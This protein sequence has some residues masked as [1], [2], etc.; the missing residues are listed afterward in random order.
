M[1]KNTNLEKLLSNTKELDISVIKEHTDCIQAF[2]ESPHFESQMKAFVER[3]KKPHHKN[4][5]LP[6]CDLFEATFTASLPYMC[7]V[8]YEIIALNPYL[9]DI[10]KGSNLSRMIFALDDILQCADDIH[11]VGPYIVDVR[12]LKSHLL[13]NLRWYFMS[14][15]MHVLGLSKK[16]SLKKNNEFVSMIVKP[17][18][19]MKKSFSDNLRIIKKKLAAG[20]PIVGQNQLGWLLVYQK[21]IEDAE[22]L[23]VKDFILED[24]LTAVGSVTRGLLPESHRYLDIYVLNKPSRFEK[25][26]LYDKLFFFYQRMNPDDG[27]FKTLK[28]RLAGLGNDPDIIRKETSNYYEALTRRMNRYFGIKFSEGY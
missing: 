27:K 1:K 21:I 15:L 4:N 16:I 23:N 14:E 6:T 10:L 5:E 3:Y 22:L 26:M 13:T 18:D 2:I 17:L 19:K 7:F 9:R 8:P 11:E 24:N 28:S 20:E 25:R 12:I